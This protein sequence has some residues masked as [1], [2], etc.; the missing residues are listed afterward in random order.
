MRVAFLSACDANAAA[1]S[2]WLRTDLFRRDAAEAIGELPGP[3]GQER[4][5]HLEEAVGETRLKIPPV[6]VEM[7][8]GI[9]DRCAART[10]PCRA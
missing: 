7:R 10:G 5:P 6:M 9:R 1:K 2:L 4:G 8:L 3:L